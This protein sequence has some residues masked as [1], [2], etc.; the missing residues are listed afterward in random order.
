MNNAVAFATDD[1]RK[2]DD[3][4][5]NKVYAKDSQR[6]PINTAA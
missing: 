2:L 4:T 6:G 3:L 1:L 5:K